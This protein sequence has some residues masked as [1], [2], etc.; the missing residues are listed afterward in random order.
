L[1]ELPDM[2]GTVRSLLI[3]GI[4]MY[5]ITLQERKH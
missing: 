1:E 4:L 5:L 3:A 2:G